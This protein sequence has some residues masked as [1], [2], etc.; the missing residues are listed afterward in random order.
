MTDLVICYSGPSSV[1]GRALYD[2]LRSSRKF[3]R[4]RRVRKDKMIKRA[5]AVIRWG[6]SISFSPSSALTLNTSEAINNAS[7]KLKMMEILRKAEGVVTPPVKFLRGSLVGSEYDSESLDS[8]KNADGNLFIR[9]SKSIRFGS[10]QT[11]GDLYATKMI[12]K[13][14]EYRVHVFNG[15]VIGIYEKIP[16][17]EGV[18]IYKDSNCDFSRCNP[19]AGRLRCNEEAQAMC[20]AAVNSLGLLFGGVDIIRERKTKKFYITE[21]N[22]SPALNSENIQRYVELFAQY[23]QEQ[24]G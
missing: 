3:T 1:T 5:D 22:S 8:L 23:I 4:V 6:N 17:E 10:E 14:R 16:Q 9:G 20:I 2:A 7:N 11:Q 18:L 13:R 24:R 12:D 19:E 15:H 21:V